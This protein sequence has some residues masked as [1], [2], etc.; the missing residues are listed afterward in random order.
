MKNTDVIIPPL[1]KQFKYSQFEANKQPNPMQ[2]Q[3]LLRLLRKQASLEQQ[4]NQATN[5]VWKDIREGLKL[6]NIVQSMRINTC[7]EA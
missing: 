1:S 3:G 2:K 4:T 5:M 6:R 7:A